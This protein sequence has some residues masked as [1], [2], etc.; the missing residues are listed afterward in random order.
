VILLVQTVAGARR[1]TR[2]CERAA[3]AGVRNGMTLAH[4]RALMTDGA[5]D[6][7]V[8]VEPFDEERGT[9][10]LAALAT[11]AVRFSPVVAVD[12]PDGLLLDVTGC[13]RLFHGERRLV[14]LIAN[15]VEWL[16][17]STRVA[18]ARTYGAAWATARFG[19]HARTIA[20][21]G[22]ER[23]TLAALPVEALRIDPDTVAA[24]REVA[25]DRIGHLLVLERRDLAA[26]FGLDL[27]RRLDQALGREAEVIEPIR[28]LAPVRVERAFD[29]PVRQ[30]E[31]VTITVREMVG[32]LAQI[33]ER[34]EGG[35]RR[36]DL[37][38]ERLDAEEL[39][40]RV[41]LSRPSRRAR[42]LWS[43]LA[44]KVE[45]IHLG[46]GIE[47][48]TLTATRVGAL[49]H[50]QQ[51]RWGAGEGGGG[52][53]DRALGEL[54]D[55]LAVRLG[56]HRTVQVEPAASHVP[57][58]AFRPVAVTPD[59]RSAPADATGTDAAGPAGLSERPS[60]LFTR[61]EPADVIAITP[62]GP[63]SWV[64]WRTVPRTVVVACGPERIGAEWW[65]E[66]NGEGD[67][68][69]DY[70]KVQDEAGRWLWLYRDLESGRWF[71]HGQWA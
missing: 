22:T 53:G 2:C 46:Y 18:T 56:P 39:R 67:G 63:P 65:G 31:A 48:L 23:E 17:F 9:R 4:A 14:N 37:A 6:G 16:G 58:R 26:R 71:V 32:E 57:E 27:V 20:D 21:A 7:D 28:P 49:P 40:V 42:H 10:A 11:W 8:H 66:R 60:I 24:L 62:D 50:V 36:L 38:C 69:R 29:G 19:A 1:V 52:A 13:E 33:L 47:R 55:T 34:R 44:P 5:G 30:L 59:A 61:P 64:R 51:A 3:A 43:L 70:F 15:S 35:A 54:V 41:E 12:P 68:T 45:T 25:I